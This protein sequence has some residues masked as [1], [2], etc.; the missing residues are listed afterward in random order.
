MS[1]DSLGLVGAAGI[2]PAT[3]CSQSRY[4]TAA[5][6]PDRRELSHPLRKHR[7]K[8]YVLLTQEI[9]MFFALLTFTLAVT[10]TPGPDPDARQW[11]ETAIAR[12]GGEAALRSL[13]TVKLESN[14]YRN[15][16]EQSERPEG[17]W[18]P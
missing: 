18:I 8:D 11:V 2:E 12:M 4:A 10:A 5:L 7:E 17:P 1:E 9:C 16:L 14:G 3:I 6:R 15:L 13:A